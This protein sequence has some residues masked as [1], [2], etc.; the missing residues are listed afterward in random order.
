[1]KRG[2][3]ETWVTEVIFNARGCFNLFNLF[4]TL[5]FRRL[6]EAADVTLIVPTVTPF[7]KQP[8]TRLISALIK[9]A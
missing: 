8:S 1:M 2:Q 9:T 3:M 7:L 6:E 4:E 5:I